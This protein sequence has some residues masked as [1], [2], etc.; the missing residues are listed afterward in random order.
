[1]D[2]Q[3]LTRSLCGPGRAGDLSPC[4]ELL[5]HL[6]TVFGGRVEVTS[7][8]EVLDNGAIGGEEALGVPWRLE[9]LHAALALA[10]GLMRVFRPVIQVAQFIGVCRREKLTA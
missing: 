2:G 4:L 7:R 6:L 9:P 10:G 5:R 3:Q 1:M 8:A